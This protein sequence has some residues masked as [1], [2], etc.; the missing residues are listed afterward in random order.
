MSVPDAEADAADEELVT[1]VLDGDTASYG[2]LMRRYNQRV[3]RVAMGILRA[4]NEAED[5]IQ[6]A[7][8]RAYAGLAQLDRR[9]CFGTWL[10]A[11][12]MHESWTRLRRLKREESFEENQMKRSASQRA[13]GG[14]SP[15]QLAARK[16]LR[17]AVEQAI[18]RLTP[19][20]RLTFLLREVE[21]VSVA[22]TAVS[23]GI[24][25]DS[26][27]TRTHRAKRLLKAALQEQFGDALRGVYPFLGLDCERLRARVLDHLHGVRVQ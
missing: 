10:T 13:S 18:E 5:V 22:D 20:Y 1:R 14:S 24:S 9:S 4:A 21:G 15:E 6:D 2:E 16:E 17:Y 26:V 19:I 12:V 11:I 3:Y 7:Y 8:V 25:E 23:L 27:R